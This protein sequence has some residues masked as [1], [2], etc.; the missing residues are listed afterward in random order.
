M[1][2]LN[3]LSP[4][5]FRSLFSFIWMKKIMVGPNLNRKLEVIETKYFKIYKTKKEHKYDIIIPREI[6]K[7]LDLCTETLKKT[8]EL[9][10]GFYEYLK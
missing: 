3:K 7:L 5:L 6:F 10:S 9:V 8:T 2:W 1:T 4:T